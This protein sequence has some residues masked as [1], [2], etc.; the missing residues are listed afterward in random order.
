MIHGFE[1]KVSGKAHSHDIDYSEEERRLIEEQSQRLE[2]WKKSPSILHTM[3]ELQSPPAQSEVHTVNITKSAGLPLGET[4]S[5][6]QPLQDGTRK[7]QIVFPSLKE[8]EEDT[9]AKDFQAQRKDKNYF[10]NLN[11]E[12]LEM[13]QSLMK[14]LD[15]HQLQTD[16][17]VTTTT[18][19]G[20]SSDETISAQTTSSLP[21]SDT[22]GTLS[23]AS[24]PTAQLGSPVQTALEPHPSQSAESSSPDMEPSLQPTVEGPIQED[25]MMDAGT[26]ATADKPDKDKT[27]DH[28][29]ENL[30]SEGAAFTPGM[31]PPHNPMAAMATMGPFMPSAAAAGFMPTMLPAPIS[32]YMMAPQAV[33]YYHQM[34]QHAHYSQMLQQSMAAAAI[35]SPTMLPSGNQEDG[36]FVFQQKSM[37]T[38]NTTSRDVHNQDVDPVEVTANANHPNDEQLR[39]NSPLQ[40][41]ADFTSNQGGFST[42]TIPSVNMHLDPTVQGISMAPSFTN[43]APIMSSPMQSSSEGNTSSGNSQLQFGT[44]EHHQIANPDKDLLRVLPQKVAVPSN[45]E[46]VGTNDK[47]NHSPRRE[48]SPRRDPPKKF[49]HYDPSSVSNGNRTNNWK[50][51]Q[52]TNKHSNSNNSNKHSNSNNNNKQKQQIQH[53]NKYGGDIIDHELSQIGLHNS[54]PDGIPSMEFTSDKRRKAQQT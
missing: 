26:T 11:K 20:V 31:I 41:Q 32:P 50:Q 28:Q 35:N 48:Y 40:P 3:K 27:M 53:H 8:P 5:S 54:F 7:L 29:H 43:T 23:T 14:K 49:N 51:P 12:E 44:E 22:E 1:A 9:V 13:L 46:L 25:K 24:E 45:T 34:L 15:L 4:V 21:P 16:T 37:D 2:T 52:S 36:H 47:K 39:G 30:D 17:A 18:G 19:G 42:S 33:Y 6:Q 10:K 38:M